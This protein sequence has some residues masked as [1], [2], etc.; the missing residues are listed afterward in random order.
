MKYIKQDSG[1]TCGVA[2]YA[3]ITGITFKQAHKKIKKRM[4]RHGLKTVD[5]INALD[6][7]NYKIIGSGRLRSVGKKSWNDL[8]KIALVKVRPTNCPKHLWHWVVWNGKIYDPVI[9]VKT[10]EKYENDPIS[11]IE[12]AV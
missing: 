10:A 12:I 2:C 1:P 6:A 11:F 8:P 5:I 7:D 9:G 4:N 3:M